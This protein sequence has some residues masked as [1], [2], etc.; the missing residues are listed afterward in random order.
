MTLF[1][2]LLFSLISIGQEA[3]LDSYLRKEYRLERNAMIALTSWG[4]TNLSSGLIGWGISNGESK[5]F[6]QMNA[7]WGAINAGIGISALL[8][9]KDQPE[10]V[11]EALNRS[12]RTEKILYLNTGLDV[13]YVTAGFLFKARSKNNPKNVDR[14]RGFG[15]SLLL[16]G[17][18]LLLFDITQIII[19]SRHRKANQQKLWSNLSLSDSGLGLKYKFN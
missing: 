3:A 13:A 17:G 7:A 1:F 15:N 12:H 10:T 2:I 14:F 19:H 5:Y 6:H 18:F 11:S 8:I 9:N 4:G 16:Q